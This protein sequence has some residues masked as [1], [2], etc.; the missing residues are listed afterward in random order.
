ML[1]QAAWACVLVMTDT[2]RGL[3][4]RVV[5]TEWI[6]FGLLAVAVIVLRRKPGYAP[7]FQIP[8]APALP[9][10]FAVSCAAIV[11]N[12]VF[13]DPVNSVIGLAAVAAGL[14]VYFWLA[15]RARRNQGAIAT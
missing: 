14:P 12:Q 10:A 11:V 2:Y 5:Y 4:T 1:L 15:P 8:W 13:A 3:F 9:L 6:F 7:P